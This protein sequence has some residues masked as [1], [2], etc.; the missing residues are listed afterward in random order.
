MVINKNQISNLKT[1]FNIRKVRIKA[2]I[3]VVTFKGLT[4]K[5]RIPRTMMRKKRCCRRSCSLR[6]TRMKMHF[7][8]SVIIPLKILFKIINIQFNSLTV[9]SRG[10]KQTSRKSFTIWESKG[11]QTLKM[12]TNLILVNNLCILK[13]LK[14]T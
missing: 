13:V 14:I 3:R 4:A 12:N 11:V 1:S 10:L 2:I 7:N 8:K 9:Q 5:R 6:R